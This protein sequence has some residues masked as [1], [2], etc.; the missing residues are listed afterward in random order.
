MTSRR[1]CSA[2]SFAT[3]GVSVAIALGN[4]QAVIEVRKS[5]SRVYALYILKIQI[6]K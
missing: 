1:A 5:G 6:F 4:D 3:T 2:Q